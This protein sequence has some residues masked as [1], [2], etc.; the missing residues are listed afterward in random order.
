MHA[1]LD[2]ALHK[3]TLNKQVHESKRADMPSHIHESKAEKR[4][5]MEKLFRIVYYLAKNNRPLSDYVG[6]RNLHVRNGREEMDLDAARG[7][8]LSEPRAN[9]TSED[10]IAEALEC[11]ATVLRERLGVEISQSK[12][13][14]LLADSSQNV[15][16][17]EV[18]LLY[19]RW[20]QNGEPR[21]AG[22]LFWFSATC[23]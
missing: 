14:G 16:V 6:L 5:V 15:A 22:H 9:Y 23:S 13:L 7:G 21:P 20:L 10:F 1:H 2:S 3:G 8:V 18:L 11:I 17:Q 19:L 4:Q 12:I